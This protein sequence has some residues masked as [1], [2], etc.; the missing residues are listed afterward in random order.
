MGFPAFADLLPLVPLPRSH[1]YLRGF[2]FGSRSIQLG[3]MGDLRR[4]NLRVKLRAKLALQ[5]GFRLGADMGETCP[6]LGTVQHMGK[7]GAQMAAPCVDTLG[8]HSVQCI[9]EDAGQAALAGF[10][11]AASAPVLLSKG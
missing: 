2:V 5:E 8:L 10:K 1:E 6:P 9:G 7:N 4:R 11:F 3:C